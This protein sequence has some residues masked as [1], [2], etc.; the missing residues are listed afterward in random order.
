MKTTLIALLAFAGSAHAVTTC[1][2]SVKQVAID[3][4]GNARVYV[5]LMNGAGFDM[6]QSG[7]AHKIA[8]AMAQTSKLTGERI[9]ITYAADK[10]NC[11]GAGVRTDLVRI[12][13]AEDGP[14]TR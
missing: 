3:V 7:D 11:A 2:D 1:T 4:G 9:T 5:L 14:A 12:S 8:L 10:V 6:P 13:T